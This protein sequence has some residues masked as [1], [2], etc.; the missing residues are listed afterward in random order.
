MTRN[1]ALSSF[2]LCMPDFQELM[3][4]KKE[5][6]QSHHMSSLLDSSSKELENIVDQVKRELKERDEVRRKM[7]V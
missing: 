5:L 3:H 4:L 1:V 6:M 7:T 2:S